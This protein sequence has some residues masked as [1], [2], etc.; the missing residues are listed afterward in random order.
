MLNI[1]RCNWCS[2]FC[3]SDGK[4]VEPDEK[5]FE[6]DREVKLPERDG[7]CDNCRITEVDVLP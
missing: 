5:L 1:L 7:M 4:V 6:A 3:F 2:S